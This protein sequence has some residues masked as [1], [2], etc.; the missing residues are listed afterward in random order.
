LVFRIGAPVALILVFC[1]GLFAWNYTSE[2]ATTLP[3]QGNALASISADLTPS[4][5]K[6]AAAEP[7]ATE[8]PAPKLVSD[9]KTL[10]MDVARKQV[11]QVSNGR[12]SGIQIVETQAGSAIV[13]IQNAKKSGSSHFFV[14]VKRDGKFQISNRGP[15]DA[16]GF[17]HASWTSEVLDADDDAYPE[18]IFVG[19][20][21]PDR[22]SARR[23]VLYTPNDG[24]SYSM[25]LTG[26]VTAKGT[27]KIIWSPSAGAAD[28]APYRSALRLRAR[29][30]LGQAKNR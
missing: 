11:A 7:A 3:N 2:S 12:A 14:M 13:A 16:D 20:D 5:P 1:A 29:S 21:S 17:R 23:L 15:L 25:F 28:A 24:K 8:A 6:P 27:P 22:K 26:E 4:N 9:R 19:T 10:S 30:L 18:V